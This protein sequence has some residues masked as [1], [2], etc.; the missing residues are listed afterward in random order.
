MNHKGEGGC[1]SKSGQI[2]LRVGGT[3]R[4]WITP[5][6]KR[7]FPASEPEKESYEYCIPRSKM[8]TNLGDRKEIDFYTIDDTGVSSHN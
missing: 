1:D 6:M 8:I 5:I 2:A 7:Q 3:V 4:S